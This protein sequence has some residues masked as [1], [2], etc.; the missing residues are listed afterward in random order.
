MAE[1]I[2]WELTKL[3][4]HMGGTKGVLFY[5]FGVLLL[6]ILAP[7]YLGFDFVDVPV[8]LTYACLS[9]LRP[10]EPSR[11]REWLLAKVGA[12]ALYGWISTIFILAL[13]IAS[14]RLAL[15]RFLPPPA[16]LAAG[17]AL[18]SLAVSLFAAAVA[19][20]VAMGARG[21]KHAKR[22]LRQGLLLLLVILIYLSRLSGSRQRR[23]A[24]PTTG[25]GFVEFAVVTSIGL[26]GVS[27]GLLR[28]ALTRSEP[29]EIHLNI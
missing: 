22:N 20:A 19:A 5:V 28:L 11:R 17:L 7:W 25:A 3:R 12:G 14:L 21:A 26:A 1:S 16:L 24:L 29:E 23:L 4:R 27:L 9:L 2:L 15:G 10:A 8:L 18:L 6:G 13:A